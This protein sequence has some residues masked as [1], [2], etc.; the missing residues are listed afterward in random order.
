MKFRKLEPLLLTAAV[1]AIA[2]GCGSSTAPIMEA[3]VFQGE[4]GADGRVTHSLT[5][6]DSGTLH[7]EFTRIDERPMEGVEPADV[8]WALG[9]GVGRPVEAECNTTYSVSARA[10]ELVVIGLNEADY[11][12]AVFD[13][14]FLPDETVLEYSLMVSPANG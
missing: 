7:I 12:F 10:G 5:L 3:V 14:G 9:I 11:C 13:T 2:G 8:D 1:L 4:I 6:T